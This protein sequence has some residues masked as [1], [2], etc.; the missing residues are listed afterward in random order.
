MC[1]ASPKM[2]KFPVELILFIEKG[3][4]MAYHPENLLILA[5]TYPTPSQKYRE[6]N[7][8][9]AINETGELR[10]L[11][12]IPYRLLE[13]EDKFKKW[14]WISAKI[15]KAS[16][17]HRPESYRIDIDNIQRNIGQIDTTDDWGKRIP[18]IRSHIVDDFSTL[19]QRRISTGQTLGAI[20]PVKIL[21]LEI[22]AEKDT[23]WS[24]EEL[25]KLSQDGLFDSEEVRKRQPLRKLPYR[26]YYH[27]EISFN[28]QVETNR[29][30]I[31]DWEAGTLYWNCI[32]RYGLEWEKFFRLM[33]EDEFAKKDLVFLMGTVHR[34]PDQWLIV[35]MI[36][37]PKG[38]LQRPRQKSLF[39]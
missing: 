34:F 10:R 11:F 23:E 7:C 19:E 4:H 14:E 29:H 3:A 31:T 25:T 1:V 16:N 36:Y 21:K 9:A 2:V 15:Q 12:P 39:D 17:D 37:P 20:G 30:L 5:N 35:S 18:Y 13:G 28:N 24:E 6:T 8:V 22:V 38:A 32:K 26:F 33:L 27:Y